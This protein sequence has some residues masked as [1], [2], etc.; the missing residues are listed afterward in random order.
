ME[1]NGSGYDC[2]DCLIIFLWNV[3]RLIVDKINDENFVDIICKYMMVY[4]ILNVGMR[5]VIIMKIMY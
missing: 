1:L 3:N 2:I 5:V 4:F